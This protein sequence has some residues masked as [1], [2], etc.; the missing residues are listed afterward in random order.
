MLLAVIG[1][2]L[3][4]SPGLAAQSRAENWPQW[5]G[6]SSLGVS[7]ESALPT[8]WSADQ[9]LAWKAPLSGLGASSPIVWGD[10]VFVTSQVG[11]APLQG[12]SHPG[13]ARENATLVAREKPIGGARGEADRTIFLVVEVFNRTDGRRLWEYR[14]EATGA[15]PR[16]HEKHNL[17]SSTPTTDGERVYAWFG[18][19]QLVA[20]DMQ[21]RAVW[22]RHLGREYSPF[23]I[24]WGHGS[25]PV[26]YEDL[27]ILLC[28]HASAS[29]LLALDKRTGR[30]RWKVDRGEGLSS[31]S[32]PLVVPTPRG[33]E[34]IVNSSERVDAYDPATGTFL[35]HA[36]QP[37]QTPV[38]S[39]I[40]HDGVIY[41]S[42]G[43]RS[44]P[45]M[46]IRP[47]GRGD[48]SVSHL[49][50]QTPTGAAYTSSLVY[51]RGLLYMTN[52]IGVLTCADAKTGE[53]LWQTRLDGIFF[54]S[55]VAGDGKLYLVSET[56]ETL[57]LRAGRTPDIVARND[58]GERFLASPAIS[59]GQ[60]FL[61]SDGTLFGIGK[62]HR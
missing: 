58:L 11:R 1:L 26:L 39:P 23:D 12:D 8:D 18:T 9:N 38:P 61:R 28:D 19:G 47:G 56:G 49:D 42:R 16:L 7:Q 46:A 53:R 13:L 15:L 33:A 24:N 5:R 4:L 37:R 59:N 51:Y 43:Y 27:L 50:W 25:S 45:V 60:V 14:T 6:P 29:Y 20:L 2:Q 40:F 32:T 57:V 22:T 31:H 36:G 41:L 48:A 62:T 52:D 55:P 54:A 34:L 3:L 10:R 17:A 21:G 44:S 35:W 30:E